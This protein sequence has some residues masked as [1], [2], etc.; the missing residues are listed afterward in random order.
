MFLF[1]N[2]TVEYDSVTNRSITATCTWSTRPQ[3]RLG[4]LR[5]AIRATTPLTDITRKRQSQP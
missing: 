4:K 3:D 1:T 2:L 5:V